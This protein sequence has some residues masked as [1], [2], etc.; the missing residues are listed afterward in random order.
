MEFARFNEILTEEGIG[1]DNILNMWE[2]LSATTKKELDYDTLVIGIRK[3]LSEQ[4]PASEHNCAR[5]SRFVYCIQCDNHDCG[6]QGFGM[7]LYDYCALCVKH[8]YAHHF[9]ACLEQLM[10][11]SDMG[12]GG[13]SGSDR[14][15]WY[16]KIYGLNN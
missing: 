3:F 6:R 7:G 1:K 13:F 2:K 5:I 15:K 14:K 16:K 11:C 8:N 10:F 12:F 4:K 9:E